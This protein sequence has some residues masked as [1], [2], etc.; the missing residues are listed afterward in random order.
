MIRR[1]LLTA[2]L[3]V[4]AAGL[5]TAQRSATVVLSNGER[6]SGTFTYDGGSDFKVNGR[7][8]SQSD[9]A[10]VSFDGGDPQASE[11]NQVSTGDTELERNTIVLKDGSVVRGKLYHISPDKVTVNTTSTDR[12]DIPADQV[13]RIYMNGGAA[14]R[15]YANVLGTPATQPAAV[16]TTGVGGGTIS[17][18]ANQPWTDTG[19]TV[20]K[21]DRIAFHT[22]GTI[23]VAQGVSSG[24]DG[25][26]AVSGNRTRYAVPQMPAGGLIFRAGNS[27]P[28]PIG[29]N[30]QPIVMPADGRLFLG[31]NDDEFGDNTGAYTVTII[32]S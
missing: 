18:P 27:A 4:T 9:V 1:I 8:I 32:K 23:N 25:S 30:G 5:V 3:A 17:V 16:G 6:V 28:S 15:V 10:V 13:A 2:V 7:S 11:L 21:G 22:N 24:P 26:P 12:R 19:M 14:R 29:S 31:V 20:K